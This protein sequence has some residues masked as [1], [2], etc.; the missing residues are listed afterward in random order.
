[1]IYY[2]TTLLSVFA[3][4][5]RIVQKVN[6]LF[7]TA[8]RGLAD[9]DAEWEDEEGGG[10]N[11][12]GATGGGGADDGNGGVDASLVVSVSDLLDFCADYLRSSNG[13]S[14]GAEWN[15]DVSA[16]TLLD[17]RWYCAARMVGILH[18]PSP[19]LPPALPM[20]LNHIYRRR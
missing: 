9:G 14:N 10:G 2:P 16:L 5:P 1:M 6:S 12:L 8:R 19:S 15:G 13:S 7:G 17:V 20:F 18:A 11:G 3:D 4:T